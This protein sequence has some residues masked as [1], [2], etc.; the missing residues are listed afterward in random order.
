M[1]IIKIV[2]FLSLIFYVP[3]YDITYPK[4]VHTINIQKV[5]TE[6]DLIESALKYLAYRESRNT[7][8]AISSTNDWGKYQIN[9]S[10][11]YHYNINPYEFLKNKAQQEQFARMFMKIHIDMLKNPRYNKYY[12]LPITKQLLINSWSGIGTVLNNQLAYKEIFIPVNY[13]EYGSI[14]NKK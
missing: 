9:A 11:L 8:T 2:Y 13:V 6:D 12:Y 14:S 7:Y 4:L 3:S 5:Y 1:E 10:N